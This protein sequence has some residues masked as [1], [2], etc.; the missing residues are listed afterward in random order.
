MASGVVRPMEINQPCWMMTAAPGLLECRLVSISETHATVL[1][2]DQLVL[3][4]SC[5]LFFRA[6]G[7]VGRHCYVV[8]QVGDKAELA[9]MG[10]IGP[11]APVGQDV[12][13]A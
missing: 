2:P 12:F 3:P 1:V 11:D 7:K 5:D 8:R 6:D 13:Q 10:R 4:Q 9:I